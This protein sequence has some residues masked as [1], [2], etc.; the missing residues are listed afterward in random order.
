MTEGE[1]ALW[2]GLRGK[3][4]LGIQFYR[5]KPIGN[6]IVDFFAPK[7]RI[8]VEVDGSQHLSA[9]GLIRDK[10]RDEFLRGH[11]FLVLRFNDSDVLN[12]REAVFDEIF[13]NITE[14]LDQK[15]PRPPFTKGRI[16]K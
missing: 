8:V 16:F 11:G 4:L 14:R 5:Q 13:Q 3:Q 9:L 10:R 12:H 1:K 2:C 15:S 6:Y 7:A